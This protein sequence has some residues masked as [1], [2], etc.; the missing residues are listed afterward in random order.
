MDQADPF[1]A[2]GDTRVYILFK[3]DVDVIRFPILDLR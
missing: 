3:V 2:G 1:K